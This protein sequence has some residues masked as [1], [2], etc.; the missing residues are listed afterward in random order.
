MR[1]DVQRI[2]AHFLQEILV[3]ENQVF[4]GLTGSVM[5]QSISH[6]SLQIENL[7]NVALVEEI[8]HHDYV[9]FHGC[10]SL[11]VSIADTVDSDDLC[12]GGESVVSHSCRQIVKVFGGEFHERLDFVARKLLEHE[13]I[14][15]RL[16]EIQTRLPSSWSPTTTVG[17]RVDE[18]RLTLGKNQL[19][20]D[21]EVFSKINFAIEIS[22]RVTELQFNVMATV[23]SRFNR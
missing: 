8:F 13:A 6:R 21:S 23:A 16:E 22:G 19:P 12:Q 14:V 1:M 10:P 17:Q 9:N 2:S 4:A 5:D 7:A 11:V 3:K 18:C 20:H 15:S